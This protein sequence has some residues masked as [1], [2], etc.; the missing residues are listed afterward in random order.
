MTNELLNALKVVANERSMKVEELVSVIEQAVF[1]VAAK[2]LNRENLEVRFLSTRGEFE[3]Y[4]ILTV[5]EEVS[6]PKMEIS[7][8]KAVLVDPAIALGSV[9]KVRVE[10]EDLG[11]IAAQSVR[12]MIHKKGREAE[13]HHLF[14]SYSARK[15]EVVTAKFVRRTDAGLVFDLGELEGIV[16]ATEHLANDRF[17][18]GKHARL[19]IADVAEGRREPMI[20]LSRTH[21]NLLRKLMENECPEIADGTVEIAAIARDSSGRSKVAVRSR[22][23]DIDPVGACIGPHGARI[24]PVMK[25]LSGEKIDIFPWSEDPKKLIASALTP[26]KNMKV[27]PV[28]NKKFA[29]VIVPDEQLSPAIGKKGVNVKLA[30]RLTKWDMDVM[31]QKEYEEKMARMEKLGI[32]K[33]A[34][35]AGGKSEG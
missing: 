34:E 12:Q 21:P 9:V 5:T 35:N 7:L 10:M 28:P 18:R 24:K 8:E 6:D 22:K 16:P 29:D 1:L 23:T 25:E 31:S 30:V 32:R 33:S 3:L 17:E 26:A 11:R 19:V 2:R 13:L 15:G 20:T 4:E 27:I 14:L